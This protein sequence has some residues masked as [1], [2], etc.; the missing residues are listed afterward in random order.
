MARRVPRGICLAVGN[1][2]KAG[3][4]GG[5]NLDKCPMASFPAMRSFVK[6]IFPK[7]VDDFLR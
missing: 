2:H 6:I 7:S 4:A 3:S 5:I 1:D